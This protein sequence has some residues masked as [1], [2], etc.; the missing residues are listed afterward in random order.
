MCYKSNLKLK[1]GVRIYHY[2]KKVK[3]QGVKHGCVLLFDR[4]QCFINDDLS[5]AA[6]TDG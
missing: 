3:K 5:I 1:C 6:Q 2:N 4:K